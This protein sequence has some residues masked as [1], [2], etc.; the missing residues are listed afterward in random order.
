MADGSHAATPLRRDWTTRELAIVREHYPSG[1]I[2]AVLAQLP[3]RTRSAVYNKANTLGVRCAGRPMVRESWPLEPGMDEAI[4]AAHQRAMK[5]GDVKRLA[6]QLARP[7]WWVSRRARELGL[8]TPRFR[9]LPWCAEEIAILRATS[10]LAPAAIKRALRYKGFRR[11]ETAIAVQRKRNGITRTPGEDYSC[12]QA[13]DLL[14]ADPGL[15]MREIRM[16]YLRAKPHPDYQPRSDGQTTQWVITE[17]D[18]RE[19]A[20]THPVRLNL[21]KL[22]AGHVPWFIE[23]I[24]GRAGFPA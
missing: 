22:P 7:V 2:D 15:L 8:T 5:K 21:R 18:L 12:R 13:A 3:H 11:T 17:R 16:G 24:A 20:I 19:Y 14:G 6:K 23:L 10:H 1:G 9:E 4:R